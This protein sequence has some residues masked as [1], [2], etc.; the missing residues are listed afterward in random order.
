MCIA[1]LSKRCFIFFLLLSSVIGLG[2]L[3]LLITWAFIEI[4]I[5]IFIPLLRFNYLLLPNNS[6]VL[7]YFLIQS[8]GSI[9]LLIRLIFLIRFYDQKSLFLFLMGRALIWKIGIPPFHFWL[10]NMIIDLE[11]R[12]FF[13]MASWQKILPLYFL[14]QIYFIRLDIFI[15]LTLFVSVL[16]SMGESSI[17]KILILSSLF[18]GAWIFSAMGSIKIFWLLLLIIYS[19]ILFLFIRFIIKIPITQIYMNNFYTIRLQKKIIFFRIFLSMAGLPPSTGF[20]IKFIV[21]RILLEYNKYILLRALVFRT[22]AFIY[23]YIRIFFLRINFNSVNVKNFLSLK[24]FTKEI[25]LIPLMVMG[26]I[27][28]L[29][30]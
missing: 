5:L 9:F 13:I 18:T 8:I 26:P 10:L 21:S 29:V 15:V 12:L 24:F 27:I 17:K 4:N 23:I 28:F 11:W 7:K 30:I 3:S 19:A 14:N 16:G 6:L 2:R 1:W 20:F 25:F 22:V